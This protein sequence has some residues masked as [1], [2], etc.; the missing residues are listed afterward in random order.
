[1][2]YILNLSLVDVPRGCN[3]YAEKAESE[4][5]EPNI[6]NHFNSVRTG[7]FYKNNYCIIK[8]VENNMKKRYCSWLLMVLSV[9][10]LSACGNREYEE[11]RQSERAP[12]SED[13][14]DTN[15]VDDHTRSTPTEL[16][17]DIPGENTGNEAENSREETGDEQ[18]KEITIEAGGQQFRASIYDNET[19]QVLMERLPMTLNMEELHGNEKFYYLDEELPTKAE[20]IERI[21]TG[22]IMLF[23]S[24][25][26]VLFY[27][28][29]S[30]SYSY[31]RIGHIEDGEAF[32]DA[33]GEGTVEVSF[34]TGE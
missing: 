20:R 4:K 26:L 24:D 33:L 10:L 23:G 11:K 27:D 18:M 5:N 22:D 14:S 7:R 34:E 15:D 32:A 12:S 19:T 13:V 6:R 21:R 9:L 1:M 29:F 2:G 3:Q 25:C 31:T 28:D 17:G 16:P 8:E 30:T